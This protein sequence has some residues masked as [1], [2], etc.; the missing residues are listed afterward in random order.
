M[1]NRNIHRYRSLRSAQIIDSSSGGYSNCSVVDINSRGARLRLQRMPHALGPVE[2]LLIPENIRIPATTR[3]LRGNQC[4][5]QFNRPV[6]FL[7][8]HDRPIGIEPA[9]NRPVS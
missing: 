9:V 4:G 6:R 3:W 8:K 2:I 7:E 5:V 1:E